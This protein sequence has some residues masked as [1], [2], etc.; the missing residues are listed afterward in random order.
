MTNMNLKEIIGKYFKSNHDGGNGNN[1][2]EKYNSLKE[3]MDNSPVLNREDEGGL[4]NCNSVSVTIIPKNGNGSKDF[5]RG[6]LISYSKKNLD[7]C[8]DFESLSVGIAYPEIYS[9]GSENRPKKLTSN[10]SN[11]II[12]LKNFPKGEYICFFGKYNCGEI[13]SYFDN[14]TINK[15]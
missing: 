1:G 2:N 13:K 4:E 8:C 7:V 6:N 15:I 9:F 5:L 14:Q 12:D 3:I 10:H 11:V